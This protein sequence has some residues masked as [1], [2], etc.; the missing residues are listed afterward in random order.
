M[1]SKSKLEDKYSFSKG[2]EIILVKSPKKAER[3]LNL[4]HIKLEDHK[5]SK[6]DPAFLH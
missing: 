6:L 1:N 4:L 5:K 2:N 3:K